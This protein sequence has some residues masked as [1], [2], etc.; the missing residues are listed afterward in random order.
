M[1]AKV[2][3]FSWN[4]SR[5]IIVGLI[6]PLKNEERISWI[7]IIDNSLT[8]SIEYQWDNVAHTSK[9]DD[10]TSYIQILIQNVMKGAFADGVLCGTLLV[11]GH[12]PLRG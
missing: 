6:N 4:Q 2:G 1:K 10:A 3:G 8:S 9:E 7:L 11:T 5:L 12:L